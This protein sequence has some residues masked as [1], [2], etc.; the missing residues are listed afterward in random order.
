MRN[1]VICPV[2]SRKKETY[3]ILFFSPG[4][5]TIVKRS[6]TPRSSIS[7]VF[8]SIEVVLATRSENVYDEY[9]STS[10]LE[11][12]LPNRVQADEIF[13]ACQ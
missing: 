8:F 12:G 3:I 10:S 9:L 6:R 7:I 13:F 2:Q 4:V 5:S 1:I 11:S